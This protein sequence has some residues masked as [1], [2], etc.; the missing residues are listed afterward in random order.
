MVVTCVTHQAPKMNVTKRTRIGEKPVMESKRKK[1]GKKTNAMRYPF[2]IDV[3]NSA[4]MG[5]YALE[6]LLKPMER[7]TFF[8]DIYEKQ[9]KLVHCDPSKFQC[10]IS[11][12][13]IKDTIL[14]KELQ[15]GRDID[16]T[17]YADGKGRSTHNLEEGSEVGMEAWEEYKIGAS[18]R[19]LRPQMQ[20]EGIYRLCA[21]IE[22]FL[23]CVV[24]AN[25][26]L[27]PAGHQGFAPHYDDIDAFICQVAG[28]KRWKVYQPRGD[29]LDDL[30]RRSSI[31]FS[32]ED[33]EGV[34]LAFDTILEPGDMLYLPRG[35]I[36]EAKSVYGK[37][38]EHTVNSDGRDEFS[39]HVTVSM[40]QRW[41]WADFL[42]ESFS[43]AVH[44]AAAKDRALRRSL[45]LR[46]GQIAG[47]QFSNSNEENR[48]WFHNKVVTMMRRVARNYPTDS[49]ADVL[50]QRF[51]QDRLPPVTRGGADASIKKQNS[52]TDN[53][54][55]KTRIR[56]ICHNAA[57]IVIDN[58]GATE[59]LPRII[60]CVN[61]RRSRL[62]PDE[63]ELASMSCLPE[64]AAAI[65]AILK[66]Y[67]NDLCIN[68]L[69]LDGLQDK[70]DL[71][72]GLRDLGVIQIL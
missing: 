8:R 11:L 15:Y 24:G 57:R 71:V 17:R 68:D 55:R 43:I 3:D 20:S 72:L 56:A 22:G 61:N 21:H 45:P 27:T 69:P 5:Q 12:N 53:V 38:N 13:D 7:A 59:G 44:S 40:F 31:D 6:W 54:S 64:E 10:L 42:A 63:D 70:T 4:K 19:L 36:H 60:S 28:R 47:V 35:T 46:F 34:E 50:I 66:A 16:V 18:L 39:L 37:Q 65:D 9:P 29:G 67:P 48:D 49:A 41:T 14:K 23:E 62:P 1:R 58:R 2:E 30:P 51:M 25:V 52:L 32:R 33:M 26:Y